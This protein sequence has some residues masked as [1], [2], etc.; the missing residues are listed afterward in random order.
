MHLIDY[1]IFV[2]YMLVMLGVGVYFFNKNK[3]AEDF[4]VSGRNMNSWHIGL[5][6]VATDVG[7]GFSIGLG[8]LGFTMGISGSW[9][10]FTGLLGAWLS[11]VFLIPKVSALGHKYKFFTFPQIFDHFYNAKVA[12]LA[13]I[14]SAIGY[15]GFT[16]SQVLAGAKL[17]SATI[18]GLNLQTA[19]IVMG[20][21]AVIYTA[22]GGLKAVIYTD[23]IQWLVLIGGLV[24]IGIP[25]AYNAVGGYEAIKTTLAPEYLSLTNVKWYQILNWSIT[26]IPIWFV[27]MTLYQRIYASKGEKEAKKAWLIAGVFEWPIM[28]FMGVILG[29]LAKVAANKGMFDGITDAANMDSEMGLPILLAT[30]LPVGLMGLMLSSYFSAILSTADSC[31]MAASGNIVTDIIAK[32][33]KKE[34]SHKKELRLSQLVT[35]IVGLLAILIASQMQ[36]VLELML[37]SYA[38]MVSGLFV[39]VIGAL[40][41]KKSHPTAAFW[42]MLFGGA[43]TILLIVTENKLPLDLKLP[44]HLDA[45]LYGISISLIL[46]VTISLYHYNKKE[47]QNG[48]QTN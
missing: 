47:R 34:L 39:P 15:L 40:F 28:A 16:S 27:G 30:I 1:A 37:Y 7:G 35:L 9:M 14:I 19:L 26:I 20:L 11:A 29:M 38:F 2:V 21:I 44:E 3:T 41:W 23:T 42:S 48:I 45:N 43:T 12:L 46:F 31:L 10:L 32:F 25:V 6:V 8:G 4:Y 13:G 24:F 22:I 17:A 5:S 33:S 18:E 36:N